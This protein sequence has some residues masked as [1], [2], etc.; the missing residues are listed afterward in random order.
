[1]T[2]RQEPAEQLLD[3]F[4]YAPLGLA[5]EAVELLPKLAD[6]GRLRLGGKATVA[7]M[8]GE[9][10]VRQGQRKAAGFFER[11]RDQ[12]RGP[13]RADPAPPRPARAHDESRSGPS[14]PTDDVRVRA[15]KEPGAAG[16]ATPTPVKDAGP[17]RGTAELAIPGFDSLSASQVVPRLEG[18]TGAELDAIRRYEESHRARKTVLTRIDQLRDATN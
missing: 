11:V 9:M 18:L 14:R 6:K 16:G 13:E 7:R 17:G 4:V 3:V 5:M 8:V 1:M 2:K 15:V 10:A 12:Q